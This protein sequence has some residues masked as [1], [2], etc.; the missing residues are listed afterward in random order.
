MTKYSKNDYLEAAPSD[1]SAS[2]AWSNI[3]NYAIGITDTAIGTGQTNTTLIM[4]QTG[5]TDS[6]AK[7]CS[8]LAVSSVISN[9]KFVFNKGNFNAKDREWSMDLVEII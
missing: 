4:A 8:D 7:L 1:Q 3:T 6:A 5:H 2:Q 9:R